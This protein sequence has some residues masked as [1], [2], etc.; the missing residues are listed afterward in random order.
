MKLP[1][2]IKSFIWITIGLIMAIFAI[3]FKNKVAASIIDI[4]S[5]LIIF[6]ANMEMKKDQKGL[7]IASRILMVLLIII[8]LLNL[9]EL[10]F[11][12]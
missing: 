2:S 5:S 11:I 8:V 12:K 9:I 7:V 6:R 3:W 4:I 10:C 1:E